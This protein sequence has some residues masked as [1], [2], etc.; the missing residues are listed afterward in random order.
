M[1]IA[2]KLLRAASEVIVAVVA[3]PVLAVVALIGRAR[4]DELVWGPEPL[5]N[6]KYW[7]EAMRRVGWRSTTLM[8]DHY[9]IN[10]R[11]DFDMYFHELLPN[12]LPH[13]VRHV[14]AP[15]AAA[16]YVLRRGRVLHMSFRGGPLAET[17]L[18]ALEA[19]LLRL[20]SVRTVILPYGSDS[21]LYSRVSDA[22]TRNV[23]LASYPQ[24]G[25]SERTLRTRI[26]YWCER[27]DVIVMNWSLDGVPRWD[28][29]VANMI[30]ID[31]DAIRA[32][33]REQDREGQIRPVRILHA[34]NHRSI[35]GTEFVLAAVQELR[36]EGLDVE[37]VLVERLRNPEVLALMR[38]ADILADQ[39]IIPGYGL[40]AIEGMASGIPV[41]CN[42]DHPSH[43]SLFD[44][45]S[46]LGEC[47]VVSTTPESVTSVLRALVSNGELRRD[48]G[49]AGRAYVEKYHSYEAAQYLFGAIYERLVHGREIELATLFHPISSTFNRRRPRVSHPLENHRLPPELLVPHPA[50]EPAPPEALREP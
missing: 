39:L 6:N 28:V 17:P 10:E 50:R 11:A 3:L 33:E 5:I 15:Y 47:P 12:V 9:A 35:K 2:V 24:F 40:A 8:R 26:D 42:L 49:R 22:A 19:P 37:F 41:L 1:R 27:A 4:G 29:P 16:A 7:S 25:R 31:T 43:A 32:P 36:D 48:L 20:G 21:Y 38:E 13:S 46:F 18:R 34:P 30:C 45:Y 14:L 23:L 44:R